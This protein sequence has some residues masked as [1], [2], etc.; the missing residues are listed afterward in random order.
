MNTYSKYQLITTM[1]R[2]LNI[3]P[4]IGSLPQIKTVFLLQPWQR[5]SFYYL[6]VKW[7]V[8]SIHFME[9]AI[10]QRLWI[11]FQFWHSVFSRI[12]CKIRFVSSDMW[13]THLPSSLCVGV[14][15]ADTGGALWPVNSA[16][17]QFLDWCTCCLQP[18]SPSS[19]SSPLLLPL[20]SQHSFLGFVHTTVLKTDVK[21][22]T[23]PTGFQLYILAL[24]L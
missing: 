10:I 23:S 19:L 13:Q 15:N 1:V 3:R 5:F 2:V 22:V 7:F 12:K 14:N 4:L 6:D 16:S 8:M 18:T 24:H 17:L 20:K 9:F 11:R 21:T